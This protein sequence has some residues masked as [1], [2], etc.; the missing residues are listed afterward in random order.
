MMMISDQMRSILCNYVI[1]MVI[2][3]EGNG[4]GGEGYSG[5]KRAG[6]LVGN[7]QNDPSEKIP[8]L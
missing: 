6:M 3:D 7:F 8:E 5:F 2:M 1:Y 4:P